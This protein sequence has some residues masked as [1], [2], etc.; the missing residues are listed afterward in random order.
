MREAV[1]LT[2]R[3]SL[4]SGYQYVPALNLRDRFRVCPDVNLLG[5]DVDRNTGARP[6]LGDGPRRAVTTGGRGGTLR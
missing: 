2:R 4:P 5:Q 6:S 3:R 1:L